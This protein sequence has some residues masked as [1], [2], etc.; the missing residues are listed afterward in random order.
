MTPPTKEDGS[1]IHFRAV[2]GVGWVL[3]RHLSELRDICDRQ[4][5]GRE[6]LVWIELLSKELLEGYHPTYAAS[7]VWIGDIKARLTAL[8]SGPEGR[9]EPAVQEFLN[10]IFEEL[11]SPEAGDLQHQLDRFNEDA[12][13]VAGEMLTSQSWST[14]SVSKRWSTIP[15]FKV[16]ID[17]EK[18]AGSFYPVTDQ[19]GQQ[20]LLKVEPFAFDSRLSLLSY[21]TLEFQL[22]HEYVSHALPVWIDANLEEVLLLA[23]T[24]RFYAHS[25]PKD[26]IRSFLAET[27]RE[28]RRDEFSVPRNRVINFASQMGQEQFSRFM[29]SLSIT[30]N[31]D[32]SQAEKSNLTAKMK[33]LPLSDSSLQKKCDVH[34]QAGDPGSTEFRALRTLIPSKR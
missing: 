30:D 14:L 24:Y 34:L 1:R 25:H 12:Y 18:G 7:D 5:T 23:A 6:Y 29:L 11:S 33:T 2:C 21:L 10:R 19:G 15:Q 31:Q 3:S 13:R 17:Y 9:G 27:L 4:S 20:I 16:S 8:T 28:L 26:G 22:L 32:V